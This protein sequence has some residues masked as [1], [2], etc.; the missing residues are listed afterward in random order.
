MG[1]YE[2][3]TYEVSD[4]IAMLTLNRPD[5]L[6]AVNEVMR[7]ELES[8][9]D[10]VSADDQVKVLVLTGKGRSFSAGLDIKSE[11][12]NSGTKNAMGRTRLKRFQNWVRKLWLLEKPV[13]AA[14]NG[15]A[16]GAGCSAALAADF[17]LAEEEAKFIQSFIN[18][19]LVADCGAIYN[20]T[21]RVG[22]VRAKELL[23]MGEPLRARK[24][25]DMG[26]INRVVSKDKLLEETMALAEKLKNKPSIALGLT[27]HIINNSFQLEFDETLEWEAMAQGIC[28]NT[29]DYINRVQKFKEKSTK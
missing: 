28:V 10:D 7:K 25:L 4:G 11:M 22:M 5:S 18:I 23:M 20:I 29:D 15:V 26:L 16:A 9:L 6:N 3:V 13:I 2:A 24:A 19:G 27:K 1:N 21:R 14:V 17:V 8:I 12:G